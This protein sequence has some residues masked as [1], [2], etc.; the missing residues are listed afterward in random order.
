VEAH[1]HEDIEKIVGSYLY[2]LISQKHP[3]LKSSIDAVCINEAAFTQLLY[4]G[5]WVTDFSHVLVPDLIYEFRKNQDEAIDK[6][7]LILNNYKKATR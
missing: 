2:Q 6:N 1:G 3:K 4:I 7:N 5:N